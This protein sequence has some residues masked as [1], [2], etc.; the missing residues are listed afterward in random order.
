M[1]ARTARIAPGKCA[2]LK[3]WAWEVSRFFDGLD[4]TSDD[5]LRAA[6]ANFPA[7]RVLPAS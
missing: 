5:A 2:Y 4:A 3:Q 1:V 7:F 6:A